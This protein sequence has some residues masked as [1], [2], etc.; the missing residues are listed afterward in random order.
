[1]FDGRGNQLKRPPDTT[2][3]KPW[4]ATRHRPLSHQL[5]TVPLVEGDIPW[6]IR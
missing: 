4:A 6:I 1:V 3:P 5:E 2:S